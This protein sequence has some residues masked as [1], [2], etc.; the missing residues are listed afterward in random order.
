MAGVLAEA[1]P[2]S[3]RGWRKTMSAGQVA[4]VPSI[5][6]A[7]PARLLMLTAV[8]AVGVVV[9]LAAPRMIS[10]PTGDNQAP[11]ARSQ[12]LEITPTLVREPYL[13]IQHGVVVPPTSFVATP[14][15]VRE[16]YLTI[17]HGVVVP[18]AT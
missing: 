8:F 13:T 16:P 4:R 18:P 10:W 11:A 3:Q 1:A 6:L 15:L 17:Q 14:T 9:G 12:A 5:G 2:N 7:N